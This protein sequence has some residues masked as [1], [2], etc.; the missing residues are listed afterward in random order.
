MDSWH[1]AAQLSAA[2]IVARAGKG[3]VNVCMTYNRSLDARLP[4]D[5]SVTAADGRVFTAHAAAVN[6]VG[7]AQFDRPHEHV[8]GKTAVAGSHLSSVFP[9]AVEARESEGQTTAAQEVSLAQ[10][11]RPH[12]QTR[13]S[14]AVAGTHSDHIH[15]G[16]E[17]WD[18][19]GHAA[20]AAKEA[21]LALHD[22]LHEQMLGRNVVA[23]SRQQT[24]RETAPLSR[25]F[26][27]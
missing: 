21:S 12:E 25:R 4:A 20:A 26:A 23:G 24:V 11:R 1:A 3:L 16:A 27:H 2:E 10:Q 17:G 6:N 19:D 18:T 15:H 22:R 13:G 14:N 5:A 9:A 8:N 7:Y